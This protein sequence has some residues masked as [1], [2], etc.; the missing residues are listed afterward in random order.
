MDLAAAAAGI[1]ATAAGQQE[2]LEVVDQSDPASSGAGIAETSADGYSDRS[3]ANGSRKPCRLN[4]H[5]TSGG[6]SPN[7]S[8][9]RDSELLQVRVI[10]RDTGRV[11]ITLTGLSIFL[12]KSDS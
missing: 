3:A 6:V 9:A 5:A 10:Q 7:D 8:K 2:Q 1:H 4:N 12:C 11:F